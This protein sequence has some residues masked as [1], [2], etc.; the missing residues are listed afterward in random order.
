MSEDFENSIRN[1][2]NEADIPFDQDA[3]SK[4]ESLLDAGDNKKRPA[5]WWWWLFLVPVLGG[6]GWWILQP[7]SQEKAVPRET[8]SNQA[9]TQEQNDTKHST[10]SATQKAGENQQKSAERNTDQQPLNHQP[11]GKTTAIPGQISEANSDHQPE[12][13]NGATSDQQT[14]S[15]S[16]GHQP[17]AKTGTT[18]DQ[19]TTSTNVGH[20]PEA[21]TK[22]TIPP[23]SIKQPNES[24]TAENN[25]NTIP[26]QKTGINSDSP[27]ISNYTAIDLLP[28]KK[29]NN[30]YGYTK[31]KHP[32]EIPLNKEIE[33]DTGRKVVRR[34]INSKGLY[35]GVT[36]GPDLNVAPS[37][38]Y[39]NVGFNA[40]VLAH[41][42]FNQHW[43]VT[44]GVVYSKKLYGATN[45]D[46]NNPNSPTSYDLLKVN[47]N[48]D[49]LDIPINANYTFL[50]VNNNTL[51]ATLGLSNYIMLKEKYQYIYKYS[52][53]WEKTVENQNQHYLAILNVGALYQHPAGKRLIIGVQPYAK[54]PLHGVGLGQVKLYSAGLS[55]QLNLV[56]KKRK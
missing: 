37:F 30:V 35:F 44:T 49:V 33:S 27:A 32:A 1:K 3:W 26:N 31:I 9:T 52:P 14:F 39:G 20:Q 42:Y 48:C 50:Q 45:K 55:I 28:T 4:M 17:E 6:L 11:E 12:A 29:V 24:T 22:N 54:I 36:L 46:Y 10:I 7:A 40:G 38:N 5:G 19:Q 41:Y 8:I 34:K 51:S 2:L 13:K 47:A 53:E 43:F 15:T 18:S 25:N 56:G 23:I 21:K 16:V